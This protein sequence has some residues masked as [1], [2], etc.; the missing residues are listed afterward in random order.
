[1]LTITQ[2]HPLVPR[3]ACRAD[4]STAEELLAVRS[5]TTAVLALLPLLLT[6]GCYSVIMRS[7]WLA[8]EVRTEAASEYNR[9][10]AVTFVRLLSLVVTYLPVCLLVVVEV[11]AGVVGG[12][13]HHYLGH[14]LWMQSVASPFITLQDNDFREKIMV[15]NQHAPRPAAAN[16]NNNGTAG[17]SPVPGRVLPDIGSSGGQDGEEHRARN[18]REMRRENRKS[19]LQRA[20][21]F[22][23]SADLRT[24]RNSSH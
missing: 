19:Q 1:M 4:D 16:N 22:I 20:I 2:S 7:V 14:L 12:E 5:V 10:I 11:R 15:P 6:A 9:V 24:I 13:A 8:K 3:G 21:S 17:A 23:T 18:L